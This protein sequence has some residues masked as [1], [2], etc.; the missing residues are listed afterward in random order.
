MT[1]TEIAR[2]MTLKAKESELRATVT[3]LPTDY[4]ARI[5]LGTPEAVEAY[6]AAEMAEEA[7]T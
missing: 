2:Q 4:L 6:I 5:G 3:A 1:A 7:A